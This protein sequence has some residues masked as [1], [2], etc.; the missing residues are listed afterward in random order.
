MWRTDTLCTST[1]R[2]G[3]LLR[4]SRAMWE[5][6]CGSWRQASKVCGVL[7]KRGERLDERGLCVNSTRPLSLDTHAGNQAALAYHVDDLFMLGTR[8]TCQELLAVLSTNLAK[9][10]TNKPSRFLGRTPVKTSAGYSLGIHHEDVENLPGQC[11]MTSLKS[12]TG[13]RRE[14]RENKCIDSWMPK[15]LW[16]DRA[17]LRCAMSKA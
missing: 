10:V 17:D 2:L 14:R 5:Q 16:V 8:Q 12:S 4:L 3:V 15:M 9:E 1:L 6:S 7:Q 13:L 11:N